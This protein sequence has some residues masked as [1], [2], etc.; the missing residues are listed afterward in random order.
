MVIAERAGKGYNNL[1]PPLTGEV[2]FARR[3]KDGRVLKNYSAICSFKNESL[4]RAY[5]QRSPQ[6]LRCPKYSSAFASNILTAAPHLARCFAHWA[7][8][9]S[10]AL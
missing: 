6:L 3:A 5:R 4:H 1:K 10:F 8:F 7:R 9:A 2:D